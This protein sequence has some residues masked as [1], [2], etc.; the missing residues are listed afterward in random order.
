MRRR[1]S[2]AAPARVSRLRVALNDS[3]SAL[4]ALVPTRAEG[5]GDAELGAELG[6]V[7]G[8]VDRPVV[9]VEDRAAQAAA[10]GQGGLEGVL[11][12]L[13]AHVVGDRPAGELAGAAVDHGRQV[14]VRPVGQRQVGD[15]SDVLWCRRGSAVK[16]RFSRSGTFS[17]EGSGTVVR[18]RRR[19]RIPA[20]PCSAI[21][22][23]TRLW[24]TR[25][26]AGRRR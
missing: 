4:S 21:T 14:E 16:S 11:D 18:T 6:V 2:V 9:G 17:S 25:S 5:L 13:G 22:R 7:L 8:G 1:A 20:S 15:V 10:V 19:S 24:L 26:S 23:A 3:A 12:E